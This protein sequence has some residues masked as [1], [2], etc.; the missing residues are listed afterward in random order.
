MSLSGA[1]QLL[2][3]GEASW[4]LLRIWGNWFVKLI[5][6]II[7]IYQIQGPCP[8]LGA[9]PWMGPLEIP[10]VLSSVGG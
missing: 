3:L 9:H 5:L 10:N 1:V 8:V 4:F 2:A 6:L 7:H